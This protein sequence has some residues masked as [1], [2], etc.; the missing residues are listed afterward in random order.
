MRSTRLPWLKR[1][2]PA[3]V[4][5]AGRL[6]NQA[7]RAGDGTSGEPGRP[8]GHRP[9]SAAGLERCARPDST[10]AIHLVGHL[11]PLGLLLPPLL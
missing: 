5:P 3:K 10:G 8:A 7:W 1:F 11:L 4:R 2:A 6:A 9:D